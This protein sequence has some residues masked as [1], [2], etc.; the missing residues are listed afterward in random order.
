MIDS[1]FQKLNL[2]RQKSLKNLK[3]FDKIGGEKI[4]LLFHNFMEY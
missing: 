3:E 1:K 4:C 2:K